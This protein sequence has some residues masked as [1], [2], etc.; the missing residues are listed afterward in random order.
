EHLQSTLAEARLFRFGVSLDIIWRTL[1]IDCPTTQAIDR[2]ASSSRFAR[3]ELQPVAREPRLYPRSAVALSYARLC[4]AR[5]HTRWRERVRPTFNRD[6]AE[7]DRH[8]SRSRRLR[9]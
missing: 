5:R 9:Q 8:R 3:K 1:T 7:P 4:R 2:S 6:P